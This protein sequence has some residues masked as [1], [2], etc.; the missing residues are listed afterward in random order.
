MGLDI[1]PEAIATFRSTILSSKT[2]LWNGPMGVFEMSNYANGTRE[3][4]LAVA[5]ATQAGAFSLVGGGDSV[6]AVN[7]LGLAEAGA[8][9]TG[10]DTAVTA[11]TTANRPHIKC[12]SNPPKYQRQG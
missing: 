1:G 9:S 7:M 8:A 10:S 11:R 5:D 2:I 6:A 12:I 3:I 4:A